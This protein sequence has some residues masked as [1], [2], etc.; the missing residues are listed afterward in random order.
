MLRLLHIT[1][2]RGI[3]FFQVLRLLQ[4]QNAQRMPFSP[5]SVSSSP[6]LSRNI[7]ELG[8]KYFTDHPTVSTILVYSFS[9]QLVFLL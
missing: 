8:K 1:L 4:K 6:Q 3:P 5:S 9:E 7:G 2:H